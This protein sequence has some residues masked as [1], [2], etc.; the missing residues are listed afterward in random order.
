MDELKTINA[1]LIKLAYMYLLKLVPDVIPKSVDEINCVYENST[2]TARF[3]N[4]VV[5]IDLNACKVTMET[6]IQQTLVGNT[7]ETIQ[8]LPPP[9]EINSE[10]NEEEKTN[11]G[12]PDDIS[13]ENTRI[14]SKVEL[15]YAQT[16]AEIEKS[17]DI[18]KSYGDTM[19]INHNGNICYP[20]NFASSCKGQ[21]FP[22]DLNLD[23]YDEL[24]DKILED[25]P[26]V[27]VLEDYESTMVFHLGGAPE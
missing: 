22:A 19:Y 14:L 10:S 1:D 25:F 23:E 15:C 17:I 8:L 24:V 6:T 20:M 21:A 13:E 12:I 26:Q 16:K 7:D 3:D 9:F 5:Y 11:E 4:K 18:A 27:E 2:L